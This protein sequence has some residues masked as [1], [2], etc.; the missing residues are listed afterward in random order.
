MRN[1]LIILV[2]CFLCHQIRGSVG[3]M[4]IIAYWG[5]P[6][7]HTGDEN[8]RMFR[9]CGF[10]VSLYPYSSLDELVKACKVAA[11][12]SIKIIGFCPEN[13]TNSERAAKT[14]LEE[15]G[16]YGYFIKDEPSLQ[17]IKNC[18]QVISRL[19]EIDSTHCFYV[20]LFPYSKPEYVRSA[21]KAN[22][23]PEYLKA[24]SQ[25]SC[26]QISFDHYPIEMTGL[27]KTW[28]HNLEMVRNESLGSGKPFWGFVLSVPHGK[29]PQPTLGSLRLQVYSNLAY[30]AQAIQYF[31]YW[32]PENNEVWDF[33][34]APIAANGKK[35]RTYAMVQQ[36][37][38]ELKQVA[39][40]FYGAKVVAVNHLGTVPEGAARLKKIPENLLSLKINSRKGAV[41]S[42]LEKDGHLYLAIVNKDYEHSIKV[43]VR[44]KNTT[45]RHIT[46][47]L[48]SERIKSS[49]TITGGDLLLFRLN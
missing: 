32:T 48:Q 21:I 22:T 11:K 33:H 47:S 17:E 35:T 43:E 40:L 41:I 36:M 20:N 34:N 13:E 8:F 23:Y 30:G 27:R 49:Y 46:K 39:R 25:T 1:W 29:Y 15:D 7:H 24:A 38:R 37:N 45:P 3:E 16:F 12:Y 18:Q 9:D 6:E 42:Q 26:Q 28:Y 5:I 2:L 44:A 4:P 10:T 14:L 31:T 19:R